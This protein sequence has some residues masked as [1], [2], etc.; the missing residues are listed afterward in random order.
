MTGSI[1]T[2]LQPGDKIRVS[3]KPFQRFVLPLLETVE[4]VLTL[5]GIGHRVETR[6]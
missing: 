6:C 1:N 4:T 3:R 5:H 2:G